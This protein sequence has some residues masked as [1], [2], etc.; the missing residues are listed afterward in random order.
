MNDYFS[1][2]DSFHLYP[3]PSETPMM[4]EKSTLWQLPNLRSAA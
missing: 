1:T 4:S 2:L 3:F